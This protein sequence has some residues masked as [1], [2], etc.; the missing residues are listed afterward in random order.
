MKAEAYTQQQQSDGEEKKDSLLLSGDHRYFASSQTSRQSPS[1][2]E[3]IQSWF[4][5]LVHETWMKLLSTPHTDYCKL[6]PQ[7]IRVNN[8]VIFE[9]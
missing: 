1:T 7:P 2:N 3:S 9:Q 8:A 4:G 6:T 5:Q